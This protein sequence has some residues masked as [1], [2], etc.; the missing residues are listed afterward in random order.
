MKS[1]IPMLFTFLG[2]QSMYRGNSW[3]DPCQ[4]QDLAWL[5]FNKFAKTIGLKFEAK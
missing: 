4:E 2:Y 1:E 5:D 3:L